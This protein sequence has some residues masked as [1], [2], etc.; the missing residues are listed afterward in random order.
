MVV[1][2]TLIPSTGETEASYEFTASLVYKLSSRVARTTQRNLVLRKPKPKKKEVLAFHELNHIRFILGEKNYK[3]L[4]IPSKCEISTFQQII[5]MK[6]CTVS[7]FSFL[8][9]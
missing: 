4:L 5:I 3:Y 6:I 8:T 2:H 9:P 7:P 1:V